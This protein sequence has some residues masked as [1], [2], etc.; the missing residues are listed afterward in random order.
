MKQYVSYSSLYKTNLWRWLAVTIIYS[1]FYEHICI[2][3]LSLL[4]LLQ[5]PPE[6]QAQV[7]AQLLASV[8]QEEDSGMR[9]KLCDIIGEL[10][11]NMIDDEGNNKWPEFLQFLFE[12]AS[13]QNI[14]HKEIALTLFR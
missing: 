9:K 3:K 8:Q 4:C 1:V 11:H 2:Q 5:L 7:R 6:A 14:A 10:A 12:S 13:S